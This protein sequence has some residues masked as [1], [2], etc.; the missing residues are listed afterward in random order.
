MKASKNKIKPIPKFKSRAEEREFWD[1]H[2]TTEYFDDQEMV[3]LTALL[4]GV[5]LIQV[6][7][8]PDGSRW[9]MRRL[10]EERSALARNLPRSRS[11]GRKK[12]QRATDNNAMREAKKHLPT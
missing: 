8:A 9:E 7:V 1:Q 6:Y 4:E 12:T 3:S 11:K 10:S 5:R 2:D